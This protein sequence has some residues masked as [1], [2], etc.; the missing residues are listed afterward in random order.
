MIL[1]VPESKVRRVN[2]SVR[3]R[4]HVEYVLARNDLEPL[5]FVILYDIKNKSIQ[6]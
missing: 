3:S 6:L 1:P 5:I 4:L 2:M